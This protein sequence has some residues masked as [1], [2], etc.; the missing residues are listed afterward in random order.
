MNNAC[1]PLFLFFLL[2]LP[3]SGFTN[4]SEN[5]SVIGG[6]FTLI[7]H[8]GQPFRLQDQRGKLVVI[9]FGYTYCPDICPTELSSL[10]TVLK[11]LEDQADRV[12]ALF[13]S[14]DPQ[15]DTPAKL[16]QY[17]PYYSSR[18]VGLTGSQEEI[19]KVADAYHVQRKIHPH[20]PSDTHYL[21][22]HSANLYVVNGKG[23]LVKII[24][25]G[26]PVEHM[27]QVIN[28]ELSRLNLD[29]SV[30]RF[31]LLIRY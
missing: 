18:L 17:V 4:A 31:E 8:N 3:A 1:L 9:F 23:K 5:P 10:A 25:F 26:L 24:P 27:Q 21:V 11:T 7:D 12:T 19:N 6:D 28:D 15:R 30:K 14:I 29:S 13:I 20:N 2:I 16:K 22:D